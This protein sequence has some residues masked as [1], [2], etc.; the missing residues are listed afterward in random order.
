VSFYYWRFQYIKQCITLLFSSR[1]KEEYLAGVARFPFFQWDLIF[2]PNYSEISDD[3]AKREKAAYWRDEGVQ[4]E[5]EL[6]AAL[7]RDPFQGIYANLSQATSPRLEVQ[8]EEADQQPTPQQVELERQRI[9]QSQRQHQLQED[10]P[11][12]EEEIEERRQHQDQIHIE[13]K[14]GKQERFRNVIEKQRRRQQLVSPISSYHSIETS[15]T[16]SATPTN[17]YLTTKTRPRSYSENA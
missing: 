12:R 1:D 11:R 14:E 6:Y 9:R 2:P 5:N 7:N 17:S 10:L 3:A 16:S 13:P 4:V 15:R 8:E